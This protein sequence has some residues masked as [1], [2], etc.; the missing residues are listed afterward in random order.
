MKVII[1]HRNDSTTRVEFMAKAVVIHSGG[2]RIDLMEKPASSTIGGWYADGD[3]INLS[4]G[5]FIDC[6]KRIEE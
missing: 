2:V 6:V 4:L 1:Q 5:H 3:E